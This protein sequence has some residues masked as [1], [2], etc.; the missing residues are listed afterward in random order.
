MFFPKK[1][2]KNKNKIG[3]KVEQEEKLWRRKRTIEAKKQKKF[4]ECKSH[5]YN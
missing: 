1:E 5:K 4:K 3:Y 2:T